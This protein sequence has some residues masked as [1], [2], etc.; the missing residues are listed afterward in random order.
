MSFKQITNTINLTGF[1]QFKQKQKHRSWYD[2]TSRFV[3]GL[4][5]PVNE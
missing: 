4:P 5:D 3:A 1:K 2:Q